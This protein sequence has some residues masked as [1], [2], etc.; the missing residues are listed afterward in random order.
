MI[1]IKHA[2]KLGNE[3]DTIMESQEGGMSVMAAEI[4]VEIVVG[5]AALILT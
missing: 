3:M 4:A 2:G 1:R 5:I